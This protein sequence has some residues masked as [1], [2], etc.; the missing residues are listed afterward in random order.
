MPIPRFT[1]VTITK[2]H[3]RGTKAV[4]T[5]YVGYDIDGLENYTLFYGGGKTGIFQRHELDYDWRIPWNYE[6]PFKEDLF[7]GEYEFTI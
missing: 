4:V 3:L 6:A 2:G 1:A 7:E 5:S